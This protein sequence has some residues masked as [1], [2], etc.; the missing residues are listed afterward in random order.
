MFISN[1]LL[2][3]TSETQ[4]VKRLNDCLQRKEWLTFKNFYWKTKF[5]VIRKMVVNF[6][7]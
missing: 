3:F 1:L 4:N 5:V 2:A 6:L 7:L